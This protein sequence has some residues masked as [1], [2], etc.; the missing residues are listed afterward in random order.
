MFWIV[1]VDA[2]SGSLNRFNNM[3]PIKDVSADQ[4]ESDSP[5][6]PVRTSG[7]I[8]CRQDLDVPTRRYAT[9][10]WKTILLNIGCIDYLF[11][12]S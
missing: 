3:K 10:L 7:T 5:N 1:F 12:H 11:I 9:P 2:L 6:T 4:W 8:S